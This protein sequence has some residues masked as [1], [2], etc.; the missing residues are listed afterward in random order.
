MKQKILLSMLLFM[1][2]TSGIVEGQQP[3]KSPPVRGLTAVVLRVRSVSGKSALK[4]PFELF[5]NLVLLQRLQ[6][7]DPLLRR[8]HARASLNFR[9]AGERN[10]PA[11]PRQQTARDRMVAAELKV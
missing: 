9:W 2:V 11:L 8:R 10:S 1:P 3:G 6:R 7:I 5:D 4:I